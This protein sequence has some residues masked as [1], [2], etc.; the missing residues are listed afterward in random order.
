MKME[1]KK[2]DSLEGFAHTPMYNPQIIPLK[3][4]I[5]IYLEIYLCFKS[6]IFLPLYFCLKGSF[7]QLPLYIFNVIRLWIIYTLKINYISIYNII[8]AQKLNILNVVSHKP[9]FRSVQSVIFYSPVLSPNRE[10]SKPN[11]IF[12]QA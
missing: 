6:S 2:G 9:S 10:T 5:Y 1:L 7:V 8:V 11:Q 3:G 4:S 12:L